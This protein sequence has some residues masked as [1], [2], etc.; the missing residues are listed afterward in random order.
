MHRLQPRRTGV[1]PRRLLARTD[2]LG[3]GTGREAHRST[4][5]AGARYLCSDSPVF[6]TSNALPGTVLSWSRSVSFQRVSCR[7][8]DEPVAAVVGDDHPVLLERVEHDARLAGERRHVEARLESQ[9]QPHRREV[10]VGA[11]RRVVRRRVQIGLLRLRHREAQRVVDVTA[12]HLVVA[13]ETREDREPGGVG[14]RPP[15]GPQR[16][17]REIEHR[18][19]VGR[20]TARAP[21]RR[22]QL[23]ELAVVSVD[24]EHVRV[25]AV[26]D[27]CGE[28]DRVRPRVALV[29]VGVEVDGDEWL[30]ARHGDVRDPVRAAATEVG[31]Q[32]LVA[33]ERGDRGDVVG[34]VGVDGEAR[35]VAVPGVVGREH[36]AAPEWTVLG[37]RPTARRRG[38][39][40]GRRARGRRAGGRAGRRRDRGDRPGRRRRAGRRRR[41]REARGEHHGAQRHGHEQEETTAHGVGIGRRGAKS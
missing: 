8:A 16:V 38:R 17:R 31:V 10:G 13:D 18:A 22:E 33:A 37:P 7:A 41:G 12:R 23:V 11:R 6:T 5:G 1:V 24:R 26:L 34:R 2:R 30:R 36:V 21:A 20:P 9:A 32:L 40:R 3:V 19:G 35:D 14:R 4:V 27:R 25:A 28:R 29:A 39:A 15:F